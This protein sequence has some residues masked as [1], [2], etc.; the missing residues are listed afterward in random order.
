[1]AFA[2]TMMILFIALTILLLGMMAPNA[3][4]NTGLVGLTSNSST[5]ASNNMNATQAFNLAESGVD[6][7]VEWLHNQA[8]P[9]TNTSAWA[10][11]IWNSTKVGNPSRSVVSLG[12]GTFSVEM[13]P[14]SGNAGLTSKQYLV[15]SIGTYNGFS[16]MIAAYVGQESFGEYAYFYDQGSVGG[17]W[18]AG[19][20]SFDGPMH[21]NNANTSE[22]PGTVPDNI[23]WYQNPA[24]TMFDYDGPDAY[25][26]CSPTIAWNLDS[27]GN[28]VNP[29]SNSDWTDVAI[30]GQSTVATGQAD[31]PLPSTSSIEQSAALGTSSAPSG[32]APG[33]LIPSVGGTSTGGVYINGDV[34][35]MAFGTSDGGV[36][37]TITITQ[38]YP[39]P[40]PTE[41]VVST[42]T[43][44]PTVNETTVVTATTPTSGATTTTTTTTT[45][46]TNGVVYVNGN[47]GIQGAAPG[48]TTDAWNYYGNYYYGSGQNGDPTL[49]T[50]GVHGTI[51][52]NY[53]NSSGQLVHANGITLATNAGDSMN[54]DGSLTTNTQRQTQSNG[55]YMPESEDSNFLTKAATLGVVSNNIEVV[56]S[57]YTGH[58]LTSMEVDGDVLA[59]NTFD[60]TNIYT[61]QV[62]SFTVMGGYIAKQGGYFGV[63]DWSGDL[64]G[65]FHEHYHYDPR[66]ANDPPPYFPTTGTGY[67]ILSWTRANSSSTLQ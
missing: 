60:A 6:Y 16:E 61:R 51:A 20:D 14:Y 66:L 17:Y 65:G 62:G 4:L 40:N 41:T 5:F 42:V 47:I 2:L 19:V 28:M 11:A 53:I 58:P 25:T 57:D 46:T 33:V 52:D 59:Y 29:A 15:E 64:L 55:S 39:N 44:D 27:V 38:T 63:M 32:N 50:G 12:G 13:Y 1:M 3:S 35:E 54:F 8:A 24:D 48:D 30:G 36:V 26:C 7:T 31:V 37:Q 10:P 23:L 21:S 56:D 18:L 67:S 9:P 22:Q 49:K 43:M 45:G 34:K